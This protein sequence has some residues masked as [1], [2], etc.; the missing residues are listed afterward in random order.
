MKKLSLKA[1]VFLLVCT[2]AFGNV[3][4]G[5]AETKETKISFRNG[6]DFFDS[7][8]AVRSKEEN[9]LGSN[10]NMPSDPMYG[11]ALQRNDIRFFGED[12][13]VYYHF[14]DDGLVQVTYRITTKDTT[15]YDSLLEELIKKY[16]EPLG[17]LHGVTSDITGYAFN[18]F[19]NYYSGITQMSNE[20]LDYQEWIID[21]DGYKVKIDLI[22]GMTFVLGS[23]FEPAFFIS[24]LRFNEGG[25]GTTDTVL[26]KSG[27]D[28]HK[29]DGYNPVDDI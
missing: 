19:Q 23:Y 17:N 21:Q 3:I 11:K 9:D 27:Y 20:W 28:I 12:G 13:I 24:Y 22:G 5:V 14:A 15:I 25:S 8:E 6:I 18:L 26:K 16:G 10:S 2:M 4:S 7:E 29:D 1:L